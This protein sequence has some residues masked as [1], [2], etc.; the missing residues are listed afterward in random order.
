MSG[1]P[2]DDSDG[3]EGRDGVGEADRPMLVLGEDLP[4][5]EDTTI[6]ELRA[7]EAALEQQRRELAEQ[8][9]QER[10]LARQRLAS[11]RREVERELARRQREIDDAERRLVRT[12]RRLRRQAARMGQ[13]DRVPR[14]ST[15]RTTRSSNRLLAGPVR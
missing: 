7:Q 9:E 1:T 2:R 11:Q 3:R 15:T 8:A 10:D 5:V 4:D 14:V 6:E 13:E 12:E